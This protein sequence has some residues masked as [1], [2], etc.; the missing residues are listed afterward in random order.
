MHQARIVVEQTGSAIRRPCNQR[1]TLIGLCLNRIGRVA[2]LPDTPEIRGMVA[3]VKHLVR[4]VYAT[5]ELD[6]FVDDVTAEYRD[7]LTGSGSRVARGTVLWEQFEA[8]VADYHAGHGED[9]ARLIEC[10][11]EMAVAKVLVEDPALQAARIEYEPD[12][13]PDG[14][15]IDFV[16]DRGKD[17]L[18]IEVKTVRPKTKATAGTYQKFEQ[19][20]KWHPENVE[21]VIDPRW[22]GGAIYGDAFASRSHFLDYTMAFEERLAAAKTIRPGPGILVFCGN[23]FAWRR[24]NLEDWADFYHLGRHRA[25][26]PFAPMERHHIEQKGITLK[27][28]V[29]HFAW[30]QRPFE[31]ARRTGLTFP[32]RGPVF[33][34]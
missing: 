12:L 24:S 1:R 25:D 22:M 31:R 21:Y 15:R 5:S 20:R 13:L 7:M 17:N 30:L 19:R 11:N 27:R 26:D 34:R 32:I 8:A 28:N 9:D 29:D 18:Y 33:G 16:V 3:T 10:V 2:E 4:V 14:R 23:G 6:S